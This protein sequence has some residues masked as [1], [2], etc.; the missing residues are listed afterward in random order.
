MNTSGNILRARIPTLFQ[1]AIMIFVLVYFVRNFWVKFF[2]GFYLAQWRLGV[3]ECRECY[4]A[5]YTYAC[6]HLGHKNPEWCECGAESILF[7]EWFTLL[8]SGIHSFCGVWYAFIVRISIG[9]HTSWGFYALYW[10]RHRIPPLD[11]WRYTYIK[12]VH[13]ALHLVCNIGQLIWS[14]NS[15]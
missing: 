13:S 11:F 6:I 2:A 14:W 4:E 12:T 10:L 9:V 5:T 3:V 7:T 1:S 8:Q 15:H